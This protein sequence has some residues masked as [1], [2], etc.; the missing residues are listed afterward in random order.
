VQPPLTAMIDVT[1]QLLL[2]FLLA[3][4]FRESEGQIP[5]SLPG[6]G[7][8]VD[9]RPIE[10]TLRRSGQVGMAYYQLSGAA[11]VITSPQEL[12]RRLRGRQEALQSRDVP[13]VIRPEPTVPWEF[14]V[15]AFNQ[16][17]RAEFT[18]VALQPDGQAEPAGA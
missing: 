8:P 17:V 12:Y 7:R 5:G 1:F 16:A 10:V 14:V 18:R 13:L 4:E 9:I 2:F 11:E 3:C 15:E 6:A